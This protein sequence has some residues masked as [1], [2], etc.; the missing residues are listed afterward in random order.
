[1]S[2]FGG[3]LDLM[4]NAKQMLAKA[5]ETQEELARR[6]AEGTAGAGLATATVNGLG[7]LIA[8]R[9]D[10][11]IIDPEDPDMLTDLIIAAVADARKKSNA[12]RQDAMRDIAGGVDLSALGIDIPGLMP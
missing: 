8:L 7:E 10:K 6:Q 9:L 1:M 3:L 11:S 4:K 12:L 2:G 5:K